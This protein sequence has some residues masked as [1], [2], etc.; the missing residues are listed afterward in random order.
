MIKTIRKIVITFLFL[1][2][3]IIVIPTMAYNDSAKKAE[4]LIEVMMLENDT[5]VNRT[6]DIVQAKLELHIS[7]ETLSHVIYDL[8][9]SPTREDMEQK[10]NRY[11]RIYRLPITESDYHMFV[12]YIDKKR[13]YFNENNDSIQRYLAEYQS[14][15]NSIL[16]G[17]FMKLA[18]YPKSY[19]IK[20]EFNDGVQK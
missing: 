20:Q 4:N 8:L 5:V 19:T 14:N 15:L 16:G 10:I 9:T 17:T 1:I 18:G 7:E 3:V 13:V 6:V 11:V 12:E 2:T